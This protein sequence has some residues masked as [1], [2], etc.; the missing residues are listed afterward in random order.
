MA[1]RTIVL[2]DQVAYPWFAPAGTRRGGVS[3]ATS[4]GYVSSE[5][6]FVS[7]ALNAGQRDVL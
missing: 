7:V 1:L 5:G 4:T 3:N 2:N 6:E